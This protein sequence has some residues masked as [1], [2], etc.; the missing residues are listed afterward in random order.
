LVLR[1]WAI[2]T[3]ITAGM[4]FVDRG[5]VT[6]VFVLIVLSTVPIQT[7]TVALFPWSVEFFPTAMRGTAQGICSASGKLGG[8]VAAVAYPSLFD[9][10]GWQ[11]TILVFASVMLVGLLAGV[12]LRPPETRGRSLEQLATFSRGHAIANSATRDLSS[13]MSADADRKSAGAAASHGGDRWN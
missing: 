3:A 4:A 6:A 11:T 2:A 7:V 1:G 9:S 13:P 10:L 5:Q 8:F 12:S